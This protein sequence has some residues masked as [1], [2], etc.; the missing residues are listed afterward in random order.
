[1][2]ITSP[3]K[4]ICVFTGSRH[5][6][7]P[8]YGEAATALGRDLVARNFGLVYG[9]GKVGLMNAVAEAVL[10]LGGHVTGVIPSA[11]VSKEVAHTGLS[12][13]RVVNSMHERKALMAELSDG[14]IALPGGIGTM[15]EFFEVLSWAQLG[16]HN[17]PCG[18]LNVSGYYNPLIK[19]LDDAVTQDFVKPKHRAL[20][21]EES[22]PAALLDRFQKILAE[23]TDKRFDPSLT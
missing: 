13:L 22:E 12:K 5:G 1:M 21:I 9:G 18:L 15:E 14:F 3:L 17:K 2:P 23:P 16:I 20:L 10:Q 19:F 6:I 4:K 8:I 7:L 11:L